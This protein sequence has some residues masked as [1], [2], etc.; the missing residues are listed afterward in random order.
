MSDF[1]IYS[2]LFLRGFKSLAMTQALKNLGE[3]PIQLSRI[4]FEVTKQI[5]R[6][7]SGRI[8]NKRSGKLHGS[9]EWTVSTINKGWRLVIGS[10]VVYA[11]I[12]QF[13]GWT[14]RN[15]AT[16]IKKTSYVTKALVAKKAQIKKIL[17][18]YVSKIFFK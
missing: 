17:H 7:L 18:D 15:Y 16:R 4:G 8:L 6:N 10:D 11:R 13:G 9:W 12:H 5:K 2:R 14:G 3:L 1:I